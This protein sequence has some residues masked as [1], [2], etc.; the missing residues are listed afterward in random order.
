MLNELNSLSSSDFV[1]L[2]VC[3]V[4]FTL[5]FV[6][7]FV[8]L[9][10]KVVN[11]KKTKTSIY[12][13]ISEVA[14][15]WQSLQVME[16]SVWGGWLCWSECEY[17]RGWRSQRGRRSVLVHLCSAADVWNASCCQW[18]PHTE[19]KA[20]WEGQSSERWCSAESDCVLPERERTGH[21]LQTVA[22]LSVRLQ[23]RGTCASDTM[24]T[25]KVPAAFLWL[26]ADRNFVLVS[27]QKT[28][29]DRDVTTKHLKTYPHSGSA[30]SLQR[31]RDRP[32]LHA[33]FCRNS[34]KFC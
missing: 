25:L 26:A 29:H 33:F 22:A 31:S 27:A 14:G 28:K 24:S 21:T 10:S 12:Y 18:R 8:T 23:W 19:S 4:L 9:F 34:V 7:Q 3:R 32:R 30:L 13:Y 17:Q 15:T 6:K 20:C 2:F 5:H 11:K 1:F 16:T